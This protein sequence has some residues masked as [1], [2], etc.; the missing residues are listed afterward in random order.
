[1]LLMIDSRYHL[2]PLQLKLLLTFPLLAGILILRSWELLSC[3]FLL[4]DIFFLFS[5]NKLPLLA[6]IAP[7]NRT[8]LFQT[9]SFSLQR[10]IQFF[11]CAILSSSVSIFRRVSGSFE[12]VVQAMKAGGCRLMSMVVWGCIEII[13]VLHFFGLAI[14]LVKAALFF[15]KR[16]AGGFCGV[17]A[18]GF[19]DKFVD[20]KNY[21]LA[22][23]LIYIQYRTI[24]L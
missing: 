7:L 13:F 18:M 11:L 8:S 12:R 14:H 9:T 4:D 10:M 16:L 5:L 15:R 24:E 22:H 6:A 3:S 21:L 19:V 20:L 1:M 23:Q 2:L 17:P